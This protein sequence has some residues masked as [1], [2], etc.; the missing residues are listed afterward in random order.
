MINLKK[1][2]KIMGLVSLNEQVDQSIH[3]DN[4][5]LN[6]LSHNEHKIEDIGVNLK[7][8]RDLSLQDIAI[9][10]SDIIAI[11][12]DTSKNKLASI[13]RK[14]TF[15]RIPVYSATLDNPI[16]LVHFKD[17]AIRH[18]FGGEKSFSLKKVITL[19]RI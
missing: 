18:G 12:E 15:T 13:F 8:L 19:N 2:G 4:S 11:S 9:P 1:I 5:E 10:K 3:T 6:N 14:T 17:F 16:G 7:N